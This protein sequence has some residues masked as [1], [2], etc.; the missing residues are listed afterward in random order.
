MNIPE[1]KKDLSVELIE[2]NIGEKK[3]YQFNS[4]Y[5]NVDNNSMIW[6]A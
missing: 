1:N 2:A 3:N 5:V 4:I 6:A